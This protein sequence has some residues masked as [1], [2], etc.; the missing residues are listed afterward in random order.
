MFG[1]ALVAACLLAACGEGAATSRVEQV[2]PADNLWQKAVRPEP[3]PLTESPEAYG[4]PPLDVLQANPAGVAQ[5]LFR[6]TQASTWT[7]KWVVYRDGEDLGEVELANIPPAQT[8]PGRLFATATLGT[9][10]TS[11]TRFELLD[12]G[13]GPAVC[14]QQGSRQFVC[15]DDSSKL[16][17][18]FD[19]LSVKGMGRL[20]T[21][22]RDALAIP[23]L[24][25]Q[26]LDVAGEPATCFFF[27]PVDMSK[28]AVQG[29]VGTAPSEPMAGSFCLSREGTLLR[30]D[31][32]TLDFI[33]TAYRSSA[34]PA[35][36]YLPGDAP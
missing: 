19:F 32:G 23:G 33:A 35:M 36:F 20:A 7:V 17:S 4:L 24:T 5:E 27:P 10:D 29:G 2:A 15:E 14:V 28:M 22:L 6:R 8:S 34:D 3:T 12:R 21:V 11:M 30:L 1:C 26:Y 13:E 16:G 25:V 9:P 18:G 31:F